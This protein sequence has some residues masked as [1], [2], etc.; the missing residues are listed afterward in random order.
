VD[1]RTAR[2]VA[3]S[4][5]GHRLRDRVLDGRQAGLRGPG[6]GRR[7]LRAGVLHWHERPADQRRSRCWP[8][9]G[10]RSHRVDRED[11]QPLRQVDG[12][13]A[14]GIDIADR[15]Y[16]YDNSVDGVEARLCART[17]DGQLRKVGA[18]IRMM[19]RL[20]QLDL[21]PPGYVIL[22]QCRA[23]N[24]TAVDDLELLQNLRVSIRYLFHACPGVSRRHGEVG[25]DRGRD[26]AV[27]PMSMSNLCC[28][29]CAVPW[30]WQS[31]VTA[32]R[33]R[34]AW[35]ARTAR[36]AADTPSMP[37]SRAVR[38]PACNVGCG[39]NRATCP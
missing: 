20:C 33:Q 35:C 8:R 25:R 17:T 23:G 27:R 12:Q 38:H 5:P 18:E 22:S 7:V 1:D 39:R 13:P 37:T 19:N 14:G 24:R 32:R 28:P 6:Q 11:H 15:V 9:H 16:I 29:S 21:N 3:G 36:F 34:G 30:W 31:R 10:G 26:R 2:S 4:T